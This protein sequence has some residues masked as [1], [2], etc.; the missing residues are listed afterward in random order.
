[1]EDDG[2]EVPRKT[3]VEPPRRDRLLEE[4]ALWRA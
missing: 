1:M 2:F 3:G 4:D